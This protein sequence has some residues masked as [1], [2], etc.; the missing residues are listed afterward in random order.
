MSILIG[1][2][3]WGGVMAFVF[4]SMQ[5]D[6]A[7]KRGRPSQSRQQAAMPAP[8]PVSV[9]DPYAGLD[10]EIRARVAASEKSPEADVPTLSKPAVATEF[11]SER[12][13]LKT[14]E[15][16]FSRSEVTFFELLESALPSGYRVFPNVRLNDLFY[17]TERDYRAR[18]SVLGRLRDKHV[19][20]LIVSLPE[21]RPVL[22][23]EL[24]G[25]SHDNA[26]QQQRDATKDLAF[27]SAGLGLLRLRT[28]DHHT[29][30]NL[31]YR[32]SQAGIKIDRQTVA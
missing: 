8:R 18:H 2:L 32:L 17:I 27:Q 5:K 20:F 29:Y 10:A 9:V 3:L 12:L 1:M 15:W 19:D 24:D 22:A 21:H 6:R 30:S 23:I 28:E 14:K 7:Q 4:K 26:K 25:K 11:Q 16:F 13:P 31:Q